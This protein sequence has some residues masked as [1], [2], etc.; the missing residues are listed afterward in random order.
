MIVAFEVDAKSKADQRQIAAV[1]ESF[2]DAC[3]IGLEAAVTLGAELIRE[4]L[5]KHE[6]GVKTSGG[7]AGLTA[8][9]FGWMIDPLAPM[10]ALG[11]PSNA[12][13]AAYAAMLNFGSAGLPGGRV[14]PVRAKML[15]IPLTEE[16]DQYTS[17]RDM[18][19][20]QIVRAG[21]RLLLAEVHPDGS[22][23]AHWVLVPWV[24]KKPTRWFDRGVDLAIDDMVREF[25]DAVSEASNAAEPGGMN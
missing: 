23:T 16:A 20:L 10:A 14:W 1:G 13:A 15:S 17:P 25:A 2:V 7:S 9:V 4:K 19:N 8:S 11:V 5:Q 3:A 12:P 22:I 21:G 18:K 24:V 6:L